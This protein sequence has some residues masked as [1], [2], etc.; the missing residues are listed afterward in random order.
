MTPPARIVGKK[1]SGLSKLRQP[2][3]RDAVL[4][5]PEPRATARA[6]V[7]ADLP[8]PLPFCFCS[9]LYTLAA[10]GL[11]SPRLLVLPMRPRTQTAVLPRHSAF[12]R[13][14]R[15]QLP[16]NPGSPPSRALRLSSLPARS[17]PGVPPVPP[18]LQVRPAPQAPPASTPPLVSLRLP[19]ILRKPGAP[20]LPMPPL[21]P[22]FPAPPAS[23]RPGLILPRRSRAPA[24][25]APLAPRLP[26]VPGLPSSEGGC[27]PPGTRAGPSPL[28]A[29]AYL[30]PLCL[31]P[32][33][34]GPVRDQLHRGRTPHSP[35]CGSA[36]S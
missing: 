32:S 8:L 7:P 33:G 36:L 34:R 15:I 13:V 17:Q 26:P 21:S 11:S 5:G 19:T 9:F 10:A 12:L 35:G 2:G 1:A 14:P 31:L 6:R 22:V 20:W 23:S 28:S 29:L 16:H 3:F 30:A 27:G 24:R 25:Q 18:A 4:H